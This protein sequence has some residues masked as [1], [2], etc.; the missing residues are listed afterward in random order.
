[1]MAL[2]KLI[3][4]SGLSREALERR[5]VSEEHRLKIA[6]EIGKDWEILATF[7]GVPPEDVYDIKQEHTQQVNM[8][9]SLMRRWHELYGREATYLKLINGLMKV[10]RRDLIDSLLS[11]LRTNEFRAP[12]L[13]INTDDN[14]CSKFLVGLTLLLCVALLFTF[15]MHSPISKGLRNFKVYNITEYLYC[16][17][18][19]PWPGK[20]IQSKLSNA[21]NNS[22]NDSTTNFGPCAPE[23]DLPSIPDDEIFV[24]RENDIT[25]V[26]NMMTSAY[27][28]NIKGA[29]G[30][31]KSTLAIHVG[32]EMVTNGASVRYINIAEELSLLIMNNSKN[33]FKSTMVQNYSLKTKSVTDISPTFLQIVQNYDKSSSHTE[34][35]V[36]KLLKWSDNIS[37]PTILILDNCEDILGSSSRDKFIS[38]IDS[39]I[40]RSQSNLHIITVSSDTQSLNSFNHWAVANLSLSASVQFLEKMA[41]VNLIDNSYLTAIAELVEG[42]PLA[43][44]IIGKLLNDSQGKHIVDIIRKELEKNAFKVLNVS[45]TL[46]TILDVAFGRLGVLK[47]CGYILGLFPGSFDKTASMAVSSADCFELYTRYSLLDEYQLA[48]HYRCKMQRI[49]KDYVKEKL[50]SIDEMRFNIKFEEYYLQFL[51]RYA[52]ESSFNDFERY[53]LSLETHNFDQLKV[54]LLQHKLLSAKQLAVLAFLVSEKYLELERLHEYF[55]LYMDKLSDVCQLLSPVTCGEFYLYVV[56]FSYRNCKCETIIEYVKNVFHSPCMNVFKCS[57]VDQIVNVCKD[58]RFEMLCKQF[59]YQEMSFIEF[60]GKTCHFGGDI[61]YDCIAIDNSIIDP[62]STACAINCLPAFL[63]VTIVGHEHISIQWCLKWFMLLPVLGLSVS[64]IYQ[65]L[66]VICLIFSME[67]DFLSALVVQRVSRKFCI[68]ISTILIWFI[69]LTCTWKLYHKIVKNFNCVNI[70]SCIVTSF[71]GIVT[72]WYICQIQLFVCQILPTCV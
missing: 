66:D 3:T 2:D 69:F 72:V 45:K 12:R 9:V 5:V 71:I 1:M 22:N 60:V 39:L 6:M 68:S 42:H 37:C 38:L 53:S 35:F 34:S 41:P 7:I 8:R 52:I 43:L 44:K 17:E 32:H 4:A 15:S 50:N 55:D 29:P 47:E 65:V 70:V 62:M 58:S 11:Q 46:R 63:V 25:M 30:I 54:L 21:H 48:Y 61:T 23:A 20:S 49:I 13:P 19:C 40:T 57:V 59:S 14:C 18:T 51:L 10:R 26:I 24:G 67:L 36:Q 28:I 33:R 31:G 64:S 56:K 16:Q 27:I